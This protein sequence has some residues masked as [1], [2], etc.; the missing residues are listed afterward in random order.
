[1]GIGEFFFGS[2]GQP[3]EHGIDT[4]IHP[5][6]DDYQGIRNQMRDY[7]SGVLQG[8]VPEQFSNYL[9]TAL[10]GDEAAFD[11]YY[12]GDPG[13]RSNSRMGLAGQIGA[14]TGAGP[15]ATFAQQGKV[16]DELAA[17][18]AAARS[19]MSKYKADWL[20]K[21]QWQA[22]QGL[23]NMRRGPEV[24]TSGYQINPTA[25]SPGF[26]QNF[27]KGVGSGLGGGIGGIASSWIGD[28]LGGGGGVQGGVQ[29]TPEQF[30]SYGGTAPGSTPE[31]YPGTIQPF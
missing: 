10:Q 22:T 18:K 7:Y 3:G 21:G 31:G 15:K 14:Q 2:E 13:N 25:G 9:D 1:M 30:G 5:E 27:A 17:K 6:Y 20:G 26:L 8:Q 4:Y 11:R 12:L 23:R 29:P 19:M 28:F 16:G 24:T